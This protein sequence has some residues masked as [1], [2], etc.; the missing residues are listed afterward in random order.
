MIKQERIGITGGIGAG[1][2]IVCRV[3]S[4][5]GYPVFYSDK[6]AKDIL[7]T[8]AGVMAS[9]TKLFG[10]EAYS[11]GTLNRPFIANQVFGNET[12]L[13]AL[14]AIVH[15]A[16]RLAFERWAEKQP[17]PLVFN[18]A[19]ILFETGAYKNFD[20]VVLVTAPEALRIERVMAR[21]KVN[22]EAV[23]ARMA[24]QWTDDQKMP[25]ATFTILNDDQTM[26][27]PQV[28]ELLKKLNP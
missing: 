17:T 25:L 16:V 9:V 19:A 23:K 21:D 2:S 22:E 26:L 13:E 8:D 18:E 28:I 5:M 10:A 11:N 6:A 4:T 3:I 7:E 27:I 1:K 14:N 20:A 24:K 15:P 12:L